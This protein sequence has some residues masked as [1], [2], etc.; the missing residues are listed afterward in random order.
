MQEKNRYIYLLSNILSFCLGVVGIIF[1]CDFRSGIEI[2]VTELD[3]I[4]QQIADLMS[5]F[6]NKKNG[7]VVPS[8]SCYDKGYD[9]R[10]QSC[11]SLFEVGIFFCA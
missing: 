11:N 10:E 2:L 4:L 7:K 8:K 9:A 5:E 1:F 3:D 6:Q